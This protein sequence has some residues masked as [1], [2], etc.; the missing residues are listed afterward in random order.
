MKPAL[1]RTVVWTG[2]VAF[3]LLA[4]YL[5]LTRSFEFAVAVYVR[6]L[7]HRLPTP[8]VTSVLSH[9]PVNEEP[10]AWLV[11][12]GASIAFFGVVGVLARV[13]AGRRLSSRSRT[14]SVLAAAVA[15]SCL[16][17]VYERP[18]PFD[19]IAFDLTCGAAGG[20][21]AVA[22]LRTFRRM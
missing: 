17:E 11:R 22:A 20:L 9:L 18:E 12:K 21:L 14:W 5:A 16:V 15:M 6:E 8:L 13:I 19:D 4:F 1:R 3:C 2:A 7:L 10:A